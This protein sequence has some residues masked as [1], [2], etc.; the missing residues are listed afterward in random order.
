MT[1]KKQ[2]KSALAEFIS[3]LFSVDS[4]RLTGTRPHR[5]EKETGEPS[6]VNT[7]RTLRQEPEPDLGKLLTSHRPHWTLAHRDLAEENCRQYVICKEHCKH[8]QESK[9]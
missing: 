5:E 6:V 4:Y 7:A 9:E 2:P 3:S 8:K 1:E